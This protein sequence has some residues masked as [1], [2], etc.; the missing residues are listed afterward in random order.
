MDDNL[1][2]TEYASGDTMVTAMTKAV[3][4]SLY[5]SVNASM[6]CYRMNVG[7]SCCLNRPNLSRIAVSPSPLTVVE[8][9]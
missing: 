4:V 9:I 3:R 7:S 2:K 6:N 1:L 5:E 8:N